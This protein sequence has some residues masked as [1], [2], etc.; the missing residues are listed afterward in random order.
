[1]E[2]VAAD[3]IEPRRCLRRIEREGRNLHE[4]ILAVPGFHL[5]IADHEPGRR[6]QRTTARVFEALA[7]REHGLFADDAGTA[8]FLPTPETVGDLPM[9]P[10]QLHGFASGILDA[11]VIGPDV[12][13]VGRRGVLLEIERAHRNLDRSGGFRIHG[14]DPFFSLLLPRRDPRAERRSGVAAASGRGRHNVGGGR[15]R[16][17]ATALYAAVWAP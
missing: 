5:V 17:K 12:M 7:R 2:P 11:N 4:E 13:V 8:H 10:P 3:S 1:M 15:D 9:P 14:W 16:F 6:R